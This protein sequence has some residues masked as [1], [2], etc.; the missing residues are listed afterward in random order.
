M[1]YPLKSKRKRFDPVA[2]KKSDTLAK[3]C[4]TEYLLSLGHTVLDINEDYGVDLSSILDGADY[5]HEVEMKHMWEG[6]WPTAWKDIN[7]PFRKNRLLTQVYGNKGENKDVEFYFYIIRG[8][9]KKAWK[10]HGTVV[11]NSPVVEV[12]NRAVRKGEYF[13]KVPVAKA[14]LIDLG[15]K[16]GSKTD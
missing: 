7:I 11:Q 5:K 13:F 1:T 14:E 3:D 16:D 6:D 10:M 9:C 8:D 2:Y 15:V 12:P 4:I